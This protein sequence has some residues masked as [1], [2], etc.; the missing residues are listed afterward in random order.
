MK[1]TFS[2]QG[3]DGRIRICFCILDFER[4]GHISAPISVLCIVSPLFHKPM[5]LQ[6]EASIRNGDIK[7]SE[8]F[9]EALK[10]LSPIK[11]KKD[12]HMP[13]HE[14]HEKVVSSIAANRFSVNNNLPGYVV[15]IGPSWIHDDQERNKERMKLHS[16]Q[17]EARNKLGGRG[18]PRK[19]L[20]DVQRETDDQDNKREDQAG[21]W[22]FENIINKLA[23]V[24]QGRD[25]IFQGSKMGIVWGF[26]ESFVLSL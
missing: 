1:Y 4:C 22:P 15:L 6:L 10:F 21:D 8:L 2:C 16:T 17:E 20:D 13:G 23:F 12:A 18:V 3:Q 26:Q 7:T 25:F 5:H 14:G 11:S 19:P 24:N 9:G